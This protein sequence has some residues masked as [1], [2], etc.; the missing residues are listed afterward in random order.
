MM[1]P[2]IHALLTTVVAVALAGTASAA[3][4]D[5]LIL[6][7]EFEN[8]GDL[9]ANSASGNSGTN[10]GVAHTGSGLI[11]GASDWAADGAI[12]SVAASDLPNIEFAGDGGGDGSRT[13]AFWIKTTETARTTFYSTGAIP[14]GSPYPP[15]AAVWRSYALDYT[16]A[17]FSQ[18]EAFSFSAPD[19][20]F[21]AKYNTKDNAAFTL[22]DDAWHHV[23]VTMMRSGG[24][25]ET[26]IYADGQLL[27]AVDVDSANPAG[28]SHPNG[29]P[30]VHFTLGTNAEGST[31]Q[32]LNG[33]LDEFGIWNRQLSP[34]EISTI[35]SNGL[36]GQ[37][38]I[39]EPGSLLLALL[40]L[41]GV[42][43][44]GWR[45]CRSG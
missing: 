27:P 40:G 10:S 34:S 6:L 4:T 32:D 22:H 16:P 11:G 12:I 41:V 18:L 33:L 25:T 9:G 43:A 20:G 5:G 30:F 26:T 7:Y 21:S 23:A 28:K 19:G 29:Y 38:I 2:I 1:R 15:N 37:G 31:N 36:S 44:H 24:I 13:F 14:Y 17:N 3:L 45:R 35:H 8:A 39:P 42:A